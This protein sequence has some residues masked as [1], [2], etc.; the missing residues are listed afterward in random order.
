[1]HRR[2]RGL[3][4]APA[5]VFAPRNLR[6]RHGSDHV[7]RTS[8]FPFWKTKDEGR[9]T[10]VAYVP[11]FVLRPLS[12]VRIGVYS[13]PVTSSPGPGGQ[14]PNIR[15]NAPPRRTPKITAKV[16]CL[17]VVASNTNTIVINTIPPI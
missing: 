13:P 17:V 9:R 1:M 5:R 4:G 10:K 12:F 2:A 14:L 16:Y 6:A 3:S 8:L 15:Q 7:A 11:T